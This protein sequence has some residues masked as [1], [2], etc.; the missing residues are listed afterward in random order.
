MEAYPLVVRMVRRPQV[1]QKITRKS[2][3]TQSYVRTALTGKSR[4]WHEIVMAYS[5]MTIP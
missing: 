5:L 3:V 4:L 1:R 2:Q